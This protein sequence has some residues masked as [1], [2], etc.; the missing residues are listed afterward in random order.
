MNGKYFWSSDMVLI[1]E[2]SR[3][4][5]EEVIIHLTKEKEFESIFRKLETDLDYD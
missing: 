1:D 4:S 3:K 2:V 5:I